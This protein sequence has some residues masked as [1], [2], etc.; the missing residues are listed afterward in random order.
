M[1]QKVK[2]S[3]YK[4]L[5]LNPYEI[6][7]TK[8]GS[9]PAVHL[10]Q[11]IDAIFEHTT[12]PKAI[13]SLGRSSQTF[14][15]VVKKLFPNVRLNGGEETWKYWLVSQSDYKWCSYCREYKLKA[16]FSG[17]ERCTTCNRFNNAYNRAELEK[18][19]PKGTNLDEIAY[20]YANCPHG[21]EVDHIIPL[22][23]KNVSGLHVHGNLQY[24]TKEENRKKSNK[25]PQ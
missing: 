19:I 16:D 11:L 10:G 4:N 14:N 24:L 1:E 6:V 13:I 23:G 8:W 21:Y 18:R 15:R 22:K 17:I 3:I 25:V 7:I 9:K 20:I 12:G 2:S 5:N